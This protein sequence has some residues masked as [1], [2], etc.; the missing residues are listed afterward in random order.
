MLNPDGRS[1]V[2]VRVADAEVLGGGPA[3]IQVAGGLRH[4]R[5]RDPRQPHAAGPGR[6]WPTTALPPRLREIFFL[7]GGSQQAL[8]GDRVVRLEAGDFL[9]VPGPC[10]MPSRPQRGTRRRPDHLRAWGEGSVRVLPAGGPG[11]QGPGQPPGDPGLPGALRQ[12][13]HRQPHLA[14]ALDD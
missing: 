11:H 8:A 14:A 9:V 6:R 13:L 10:P 3:T 1:A 12:P 2:L 5:R 4:H 7:L